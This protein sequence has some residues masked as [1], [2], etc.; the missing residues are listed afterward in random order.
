MEKVLHHVD[1][2]Q[3]DLKVTDPERHKKWIGVDKQPMHAII[4]G[5][6]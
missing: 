1:L 5:C 6:L 2:V 3:H 4:L